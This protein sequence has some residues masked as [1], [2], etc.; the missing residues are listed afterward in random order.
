MVSLEEAHTVMK[1]QWKLCFPAP[2]FVYNTEFTVILHTSTTNKRLEAVSI[3][4]RLIS[5]IIQ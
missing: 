2:V 4:T 3:L 5:Q 1:R